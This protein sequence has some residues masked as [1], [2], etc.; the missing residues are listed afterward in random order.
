[1]SDDLNL[2]LVDITGK[3]FPISSLKELESLLES[4]IQHW[5]KVKEEFSQGEMH[6]C[7]SFVSTMEQALKQIQS[8]SDYNHDQIKNQIEGMRRNSFSNYR[9]SWVWSGHPFVSK[10]VE[11]HRINGVGSATAFLDFVAKQ[12]LTNVNHYPSF[13]GAMAGY[14]FMNQDSEILSR[15][16]GEEESI[17]RLRLRL[18]EVT[19]TAITQTEKF[20][21]SIDDWDKKRRMSWSDFVKKTEQSNLEENKA[22]T[23]KFDI[24]MDEC[25]TGISTL[26]STY[27]EL[28]RLQKPAQY[29][30][31]ASRKYGIQ[32][33]WWCIILVLVV[34]IGIVYF[35]DFFSIWLSG[36]QMEVQLNTVQGVILFG[37]FVAVYAFLLRTLS[38]LA[39]S[40][41][42]LM[43]DAEE[44]EQLT[45]L[46]LA[47]VND[48]K[49]DDDSREIVL[50]ALFSRTETGL[51]VSESGPTMPG[52]GDL[53]R[54][55]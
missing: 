41:F 3:S 54:N 52:I 37:T 10:F 4:E 30:N 9:S 2:Q 48:K 31:A 22:R 40:S 43:R 8:W 44:R 15:R 18:E 50:Q 27:Q 42:H 14:E 53:M 47:L 16:K 45:Y 46:Y 32:G 17:D 39:F 13:L 12:S 51:L 28:L 29:W 1:M 5:K 6:P 55:R 34:L 19:N 23:E 25:G 20:T 24:Y 26:E 38:R 7:I 11:S 33:M 49:I 35:G 21:D 36:Q